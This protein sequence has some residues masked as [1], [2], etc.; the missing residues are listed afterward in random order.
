[1]Q[2]LRHHLHIRIQKNQTFLRNSFL[3]RQYM[4]LPLVGMGLQ[5]RNFLLACSCR[6]FEKSLSRTQYLP[7]WRRHCF[8][9]SHVVSSSFCRFW[10]HR[11]LMMQYKQRRRRRWW[12]FWKISWPITVL[13]IFL[14]IIFQLDYY[15]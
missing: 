2:E 7:L 6:C 4:K 13:K 15:Y 14:S 12:Y 10:M 1:M 3:S 5:H 8:A 11:R 9:A